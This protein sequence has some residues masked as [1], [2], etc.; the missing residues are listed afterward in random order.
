MSISL[1]NK[2]MVIVYRYLTGK[3]DREE[4]T[5]QLHRTRTNTYY[6]IG[7]ATHYWLKK[8][9]LKFK[10]ISDDRELGGTDL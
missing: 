2:D 5:K 7:R 6:Y 9:V 8:G 10:R 4:M 3:I 1:K